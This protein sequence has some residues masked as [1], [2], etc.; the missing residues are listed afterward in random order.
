MHQNLIIPKLN[1]PVYL[2]H[3]KN[4]IMINLFHFRHKKH[5][6][7]KHEDDEKPSDVKDDT[8]QDILDHGLLF[9]DV[10]SIIIKV[11]CHILDAI[12]TF[13]FSDCV[14]ILTQT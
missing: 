7:R 14:F 10:N 13:I 5:K 1:N 2:R 9:Y 12:M 6:K 3:I 8:K 4:K 11:K